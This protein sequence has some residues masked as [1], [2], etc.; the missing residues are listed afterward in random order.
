M[1]TLGE[2]G[3]NLLKEVLL[4]K[5]N[6]CTAQLRGPRK[7]TLWGLTLHH[8]TNHPWQMQQTLHLHS[9]QD[10]LPQCPDHTD[11]DGLLLPTSCT[12]DVNFL[13]ASFL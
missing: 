1:Q 10:S 3:L 7:E 2:Q 4:R 12:V 9:C 6:C 13:R 11:Q 5:K 8:A